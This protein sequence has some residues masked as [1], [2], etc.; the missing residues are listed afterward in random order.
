MLFRPI[1]LDDPDDQTV[2]TDA[3]PAGD[4]LAP[5]ADLATVA[6]G[7]APWASRA[8]AANTGT[9]THA[10][11]DADAEQHT[12]TDARTDAYPDIGTG[13]H[14]DTGAPGA[15]PGAADPGDGTDPRSRTA[16]LP[17]YGAAGPGGGHRPPGRRGRRT[18][19][20]GPGAG[21]RVGGSGRRAAGRRAAGRR[22]AGRRTVTRRAGTLVGAVVAVLSLT[23]VAALAMFGMPGHDSPDPSTTTVTAPPHPSTAPWATGSASSAPSRQ[24]ELPGPMPGGYGRGRT[25]PVRTSG[26]TAAAGDPPTD[27]G[28]APR[29]NAVPPAPD[30]GGAVARAP[31]AG[32]TGSTG[33]YS[34]ATEALPAGSRVQIPTGAVDWLV[35]GNGWGGV[36]NHRAG[37]PFPLL[38]PTVSGTP[39]PSS[40][41]VAWTDGT[42]S[43]AGSAQT[44]SLAVQGTAQLTTFVTRTRQLDVYLSSSTGQVRIT[45]ASIVD[46]RTFTV[47]L[48]AAPAGAATDARITLTLPG[49]IAATRVSISADG[50]PWTLA[51]AVLR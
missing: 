48:P 22:A 42:P 31:G 51:A 37:V 50:A 25:A 11:A 1:D 27:A 17:L 45:I 13:A 5:D 40:P 9:H 6:G 3:G 49:Q 10:D 18:R 39:T 26:A 7:H 29:P 38:V 2:A 43:L 46:T 30:T 23:M 24:P 32:T 47:T 12:D 8:P 36:S 20:A 15:P 44:D 35:F 34:S 4:A 14:P 41:G 28:R 19:H 33:I 16:P 21:G